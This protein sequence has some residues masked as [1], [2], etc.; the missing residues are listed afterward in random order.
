[1]LLCKINS[2]VLDKD[3]ELLQESQAVNQELNE[4]SSTVKAK[5]QQELFMEYYTN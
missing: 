3:K 4:L 1:M 5:R 2:E